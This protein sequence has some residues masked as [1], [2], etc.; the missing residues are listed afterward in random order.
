MSDGETHM[1]IKTHSHGCVRLSFCMNE[2]LILCGLCFGL[3]PSIW[4]IMWIGWFVVWELLLWSFSLII[5]QLKYYHHTDYMGRTS[6]SS[7]V[8]L[9]V[10]GISQV[11]DGSL[12]GTGQCGYVELKV[13]VLGAPVPG[14]TVLSA[15][16]FSSGIYQGWVPH[17]KEC[18]SLWKGCW[19]SHPPSLNCY[20]TS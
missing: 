10:S 1:T 3:D 5:E 17:P 19:P 13:W 18:A 8:L 14:T 4:K 11:M 9:I 16:L 2:V 12:Y 7:H 20:W 6:S 15:R